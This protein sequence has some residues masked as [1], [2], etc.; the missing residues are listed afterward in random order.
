MGS[1]LKRYWLLKMRM[2][3]PESKIAELTRGYCSPAWKLACIVAKDP[4]QVPIL[5]QSEGTKGSAAG[6]QSDCSAWSFFGCFLLEPLLR[7]GL[8]FLLLRL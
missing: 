6:S 2:V 7:L 8:L 5:R 1:R 4:E 3:D